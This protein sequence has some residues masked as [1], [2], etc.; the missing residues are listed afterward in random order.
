MLTILQLKPT[1]IAIPDK[2]NNI[3]TS[4]EDPEDITMSYVLLRNN[5]S[6]SSKSLTKRGLFLMSKVL[7]S[8]ISE[9]N[10]IILWARGS[11]TKVK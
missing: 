6:K 10:S 11:S 5:P 4:G 8:S 1:L 2:N 9:V 3:A 7:T